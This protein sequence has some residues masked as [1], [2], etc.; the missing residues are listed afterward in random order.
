MQFVAWY[1]I[2]DSAKKK[3]WNAFIRESRLEHV[4]EEFS[5]IVEALAGFL[6]PISGQLS[7]SGSFTGTWKAPGPWK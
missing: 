5:V 2:R 4:P 7:E 3:Q 6:G 1:S